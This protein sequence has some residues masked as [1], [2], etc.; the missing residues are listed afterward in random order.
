MGNKRL[1]S[2]FLNNLRCQGH[3]RAA[4]YDTLRA[5]TRRQEKIIHLGEVT[6]CQLAS[7]KSAVGDLLCLFSDDLLVFILLLSQIPTSPKCKDLRTRTK[8]FLAPGACE[9]G[10]LIT[11][12][13][14]PQNEH[15]SF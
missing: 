6:V 7:L 3:L 10:R 4:E 12:A 14:F 9:A 15:A 13:A 5:H 2:A 8:R 1:C 11:G